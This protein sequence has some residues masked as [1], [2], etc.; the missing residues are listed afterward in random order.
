MDQGLR[1]R[2]KKEKKERDTC[3]K[4]KEK[5]LSAK[6]S[7]LNKAQGLKMKKSKKASFGLEKEIKQLKAESSG[8]KRKKKK[9]KKSEL[10]TWK[11]NKTIQS[12]EIR[13]RQGFEPKKKKK[14][15]IQAIKE[16]KSYIGLRAQDLTRLRA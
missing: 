3:N 13:A 6:S 15:E 8:P 7:H 14:N 4:R 10:R 9:N 12:W 11:G 16:K 1:K 5:Q 2:K